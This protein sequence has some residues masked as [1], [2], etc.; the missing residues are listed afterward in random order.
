M[1]LELF[2]VWADEPKAAA[3]AARA[4]P[5][6]SGSRACAGYARVEVRGDGAP[7]DATILGDLLGLSGARFAE[8]TPV[9]MESTLL[10]L[11]RHA[12]A[13]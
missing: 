6:V 3:R 13:P 2:R 4:L 9:D 10:A 1:S 11:A 12:E 8:R 5:Y 7:N